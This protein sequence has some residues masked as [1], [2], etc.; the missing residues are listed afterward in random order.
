M[1]TEFEAKFYPVKK[2][3]N[4]KKLNDLGAIMIYPEYLQKRVVYSNP[5]DLEGSWA[6]VRQ[7]Y[8][9][10]TMSLKRVIGNSINDQKE[11]EL[12]INDFQNASDLLSTLGCKQKAYQ[13]TKREKWALDGAEIVIDTWPFL[14]P[15]IEIEAEN[16]KNVINTSKKLGFNFDNA[17]FGAIDVIYEKVYGITKEKINNQTSK[18]IF[19]MENPFLK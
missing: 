18:I 17:I 15:L 3:D 10:I 14:E 16:E 9:K 19:E 11:I 5:S 4:R 12:V 1:R 6:R 13:E 7:E 2:E 8:D